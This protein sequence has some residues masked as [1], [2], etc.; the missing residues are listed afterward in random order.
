MEI[1]DT[2]WQGGESDCLLSTGTAVTVFWADGE[3]VV[4]HDY[5]EFVA[6]IIM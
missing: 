6:Q 3:A 4:L 5:G 2:V 1:N